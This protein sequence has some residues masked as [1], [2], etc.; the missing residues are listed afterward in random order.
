MKIMTSFGINQIE[1]LGNGT[2]DYSVTYSFKEDGTIFSRSTHLTYDENIH[3]SEVRDL[4]QEEC[5]HLIEN[6]E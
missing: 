6:E 4:I 3:W 2:K 1:D 5:A